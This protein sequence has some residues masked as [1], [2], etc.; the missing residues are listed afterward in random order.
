MS[1]LR[2]TGCGESGAD[3]DREKSD[4]QCTYGLVARNNRHKDFRRMDNSGR[5]GA[6][7][8][9][10]DN[11]SGSSENRSIRPEIQN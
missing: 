9:R 4:A 6:D 2:L 3:N 8:I 11:N 10:K 5:T 1:L 7:S